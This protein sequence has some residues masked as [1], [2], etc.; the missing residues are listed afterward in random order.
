MANPYTGFAPNAR[1]FTRLLNQLADAIDADYEKVVRLAVLKVFKHIVEISPVLT[2]AY[3]ASHSICSGRDP[4]EDEGILPGGAE[5]SEGAIGGWRWQMGDG[6]IWI[7]NNQ[8][9]AK[10]LE[11]GSSTQAPL[12]IYRIAVPVFN[13]MLREELKQVKGF[14]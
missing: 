9:Y 1:V 6:V 10:K 8:P 2:G 4:I 12:G 13:R 3:K 7:F 11:D 5:G 14:K